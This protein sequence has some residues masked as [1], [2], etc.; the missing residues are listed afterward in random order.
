MPDQTGQQLGNYTLIKMLGS[1]GFAEVYLGE[2]IHLGTPAAIKLLTAKLSSEEESH[3][4]EEARTIAWLKHPNIIRVLEFGVQDGVPYLVM[5]YAPNGTLRQFFLK[6]GKYN[7][8]TILPF[9][10]QV[11]GALQFAHDR[12]LIHR[13]IKPENMLLGENKEVLLSDFGIAVVAQSS[14]HQDMQEVVGTLAYMAPEQI[15]A[16]PRPASD[17]Y[18]LAVVI[19]EWLTGTRPFSG[20]MSEILAKQVLTPPPP[21]RDH[22]PHVSADLEQVVLTALAKDPKD[23]FASIRAFANAFEQA[24][25][26]QGASVPPVLDIPRVAPSI[27]GQA[28]NAISAP[29]TPANSAPG[30]NRQA[31]YAPAGPAS[32]PAGP[33]FAGRSEPYPNVNSAPNAA[34]SNAL[35]VAATAISASGSPSEPSGP[36]PSSASGGSDFLDAP[37]IL[38]TFLPPTAPPQPAQPATPSAPSWQAAQPIPSTPPGGWQAAQPISSTPPGW[39]N[40]PVGPVNTN[41]PTFFTS[42]PVGSGAPVAVSAPPIPAPAPTGR[43]VSRR[44]VLI[45]GVAGVAGLAAIGGGIT[46]FVASGSGPTTTTNAPPREKPLLSYKGHSGAVFDVAWSIDGQRIASAGADHTVQVWDALTGANA[47]VFRGHS[48]IVRALSFS[49]DKQYLASAS[50]DKTVLIWNLASSNIFFSYTGHTASVSTVSWS[51]GGQ[52]IASG[53]YDQTVQI[54]STS[55]TNKTLSSF[56]L[57]GNANYPTWLAWSS[58][59][60]RLA[61]ASTDKIARIWDTATSKFSITYQAHTARVNSVAWAPDGA[62]V[63]SGGSDK[64]AIIWRSDNGKTAN[65]DRSHTGPVNSVAWSPDG[66][67]IATASSDT[68]VQILDATTYQKVRTFSGHSQAVQAVAWSPDSV[69][70]VSSALDGTAMVW[71]ALKET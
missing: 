55:S 21:L 63:V 53:G 64:K 10:Q 44:K 25:L 41:P 22:V 28:G 58:T 49:P 48:K 43:G 14:R 67:Y 57:T 34:P 24:A 8:L 71:K 27:E 6:G 66:N 68:T 15:Q 9:V 38:G 30:S 13:D 26:S 54:W 29:S 18:S 12:K 52:Q 36:T 61:L 60:T 50:D 39:V 51:P 62:Y 4:R 33:P 32:T 17:Q 20:S 46:W 23:R 45:A 59:G 56:T 31:Y 42:G 69:Y 7:P 16:H 47:T 1:G 19:Y 37:T 35:D 70:V 65:I 11:A 5:D 40:T 3:F 2:H